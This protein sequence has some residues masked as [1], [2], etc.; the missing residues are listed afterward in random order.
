MDTE[1]LQ[2][3]TE[4]TTPSSDT[5]LLVTDVSD[6]NTSKKIQY[7]NLVPTINNPLTVAE[8]GTGRQTLTS[9]TILAG[10]GTSPVS[11]YTTTGSGTVVALATSP[12]LV[13]PTLGVAT[14]TSINGLTLTS[15]TGVITV[16]N[17][18]TLT[19]SDS[20][21]LATNSITFAGGEVV[22]FTATNALT[23][24]T[25]GSTNVTLP[26]S[27]TLAT[28]AGTE[29]LT[30]KTI[31]TT[32]LISFNSPQGYLINGKIVPSVSSNNITVAIKGLN[33]SDPS[34]TNPV[35]IRIGD[36]IRAI[37]AA[38]SVTKNAGTN[39]FNA[40]AA[41][42]A[43]QEIDYFVYLGYNA[44][45]G[46]TIGFARIPYATKYGD[47]SATSTNDHYCAISTITT[48]SATDYYELIGRFAATLSA[49]AG[50]TWTVPAF[51][52]INLIQRPIFNTRWLTW[53]LSATGGSSI[54]GGG[55]QYQIT[56][57]SLTVCDGSVD[58]TS[59]GTGKT[60][61]VPMLSS[62]S[63]G[64]VYFSGM[65]PI[66][67]NG[68]NTTTYGHFSLAAGASTVNV[69]ISWYQGAWTGSNAFSFFITNFKYRI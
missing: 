20:T 43:A 9:G 58:G 42:T 16:T 21:T 68:S 3:L 15:S 45:D 5:L 12:V 13:T 25:T 64:S 7:S 50:Y 29:V 35:Y 17:G 57:D 8:G 61:E 62:A 41:V 28:L 30:N 34:A 63:Y 10:N 2:N 24:T 54:T 22:T 65:T 1:L 19:V 18:K 59:T 27:G 6:S 48:A 33:G 36:T 53:V 51:T 56:M 14:A 40:G 55:E 26:T 39:W 23:L 52:A 31:G 60:F 11:L 4:L 38:L 67:N 32:N 69:Y 44:T 49:G 66:K 46:V 47:F 37:T